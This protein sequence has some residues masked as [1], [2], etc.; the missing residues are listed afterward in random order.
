MIRYA[1]RHRKSKQYVGFR[2]EKWE[3][4]TD[5]HL[6]FDEENIWLKADDALMQK[7]IKDRK[8]NDASLQVSDAVL[9]ALKDWDLEVMEIDF[10]DSNWW[11]D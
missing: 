9:K 5:T 7:L 10:P 6:D 11:D 3:Y 8:S 2:T 1:L 4:G